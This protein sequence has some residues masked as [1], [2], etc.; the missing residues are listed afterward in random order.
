[1]PQLQ[2]DSTHYFV[3]NMISTF[4]N[5]TIKTIVAGMASQECKSR[6]TFFSL[7]PLGRM[8]NKGRLTALYT[9]YI[10]IYIKLAKKGK[11]LGGLI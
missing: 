10:Y 3:I 8:N 1:M 2:G 11:D 6:Q 7:S 5:A 9:I 4:L